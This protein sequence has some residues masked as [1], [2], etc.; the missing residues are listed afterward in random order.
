MAAFFLSRIGG[1]VMVAGILV[2]LI[3]GM[4]L[5]MH[6]TANTVSA[7]QNQ[8]SQLSQQASALQLA[9]M[10]LKIDVTHVQQGSRRPI[11]F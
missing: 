4:L 5:H 2:L 10:A 7:L 6:L 3:G 11:K 8:V 9:N 1:Y